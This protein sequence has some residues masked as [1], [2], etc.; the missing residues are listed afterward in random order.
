MP[1]PEGLTVGLNVIIPRT[2]FVVVNRPIHDQSIRWFMN[3][4]VPV[5]TAFGIFPRPSSLPAVS[6]DTTLLE[7]WDN[8]ND[9]TLTLFILELKDN[10]K[11]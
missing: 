6:K 1:A 4:W 11:D 2:A 3:A 8:N 9:K 7:S 10:K 5:L